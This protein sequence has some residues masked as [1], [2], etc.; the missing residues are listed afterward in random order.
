MKQI[1]ISSIDLDKF[2]T[3]QNGTLL[4]L[5]LNQDNIE[6]DIMIDAKMKELSIQKLYEKYPECNCL[7]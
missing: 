3:Y 6:I 2:L 4:R 7:E 5:C 1:I